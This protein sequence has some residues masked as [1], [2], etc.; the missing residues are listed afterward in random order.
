M[1]GSHPYTC[2]NLGTVS[3]LRVEPA[4][5]S[6]LTASAFDPARMDPGR[7]SARRTQAGPGAGVA[8]AQLQVERS[9]IRLESNDGPDRF[10]QEWFAA[11]R[12][13]PVKSSPNGP[14]PFDY[15]R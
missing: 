1:A 12:L 8:K 10:V 2:S 5:G 7:T 15:M 14:S 3:N 6:G 4:Q 13:W 9:S 11:E